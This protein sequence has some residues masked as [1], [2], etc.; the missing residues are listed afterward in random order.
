LDWGRNDTFSIPTWAR[1][2]HHNDENADA[3]LFSYSDAPAVVA[4]GLAREIAG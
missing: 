2:A 4:L 1:H 3:L